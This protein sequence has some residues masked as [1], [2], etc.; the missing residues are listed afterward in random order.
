MSILHFI[1]RL[2][3]FYCGGW[4][5]PININNIVGVLRFGLADKRISN[6][7]YLYVALKKT[8]KYHTKFN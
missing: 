5:P 3:D 6:I 4:V 8:V 1:L 2:M 7:I